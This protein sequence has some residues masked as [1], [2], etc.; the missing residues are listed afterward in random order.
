[1]ELKDKILKYALQNAVKFDGKASAGAVIGK[2]LAE[3][4]KLKSNMKEIAKEVNSII[5][6]ISSLSVEEQTKR[7]HE[8]A[9]DLLEKKE[10]KERNIFEFL[11]FNESD[12]I[13]TAFP[14]G[15]EKYPHIGHAKSCLL[16]YL[17]AKQYN[18]RFILR[19][20]DTNP[21]TVKKEYYDAM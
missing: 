21:K 19:F 7:L 10:K 6:D 18:G 13:T 12:K 16:N 4:P 17:L 2:V 15:P 20:E 11:G 5:K 9:P 14:P 3:D 8:I 1:M